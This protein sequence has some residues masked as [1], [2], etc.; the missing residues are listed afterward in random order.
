MLLALGFLVSRSPESVLA[1]VGFLVGAVLVINLLVDLSY[2]A[3]DPRL[4]DGGGRGG[5]PQ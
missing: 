3:I 4:R 5:R 2:L 1:L